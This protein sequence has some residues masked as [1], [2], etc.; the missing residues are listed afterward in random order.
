M[1]AFALRDAVANRASNAL[2][3]V[4]RHLRAR[5]LPPPTRWGS[6]YARPISFIKPDRDVLGKA[7]K[8]FVAIEYWPAAALH[9]TLIVA[10]D[11]VKVL[12]S[13]LKAADCVHG[14]GASQ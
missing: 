11:G 6:A 13:V 5:A 2:K 4:V 7:L 10:R 12:V 9:K 8:D 3:G 14:S 1:S